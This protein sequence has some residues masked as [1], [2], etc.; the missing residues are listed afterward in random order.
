MAMRHHKTAG[1]EHGRRSQNRAD[2]VWIGNL[3]EHDQRPSA[4]SAREFFPFRFRQRL[5]LERYA[6]MHRVRSKQTIEVARRD[7]VDFRGDRS[8][9]FNQTAF[10]VLGQ[11]KAMNA[12]RRVSQRGLHGMQPKE[13]ER[14]LR[15]ISVAR[16]CDVP[17]R[18]FC[19]LVHGVGLAC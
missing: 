5:G 2:V 3:I 1:A 9:G 7:A 11:Q 14:A 4:G 18:L 16:L 10:R 17:V 8:D 13:P 15:I 19:A 12:A 6:L